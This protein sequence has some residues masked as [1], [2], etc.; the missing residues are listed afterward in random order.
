MIGRDKLTPL[1]SQ[2]WRE[3]W[4]RPDGEHTAQMGH[5]GLFKSTIQVEIGCPLWLM[6][7]P[8][9]RIGIIRKT[10]S[11]AAEQL[12][13]IRRIMEQDEVRDLFRYVHGK[14]P[15]FTTKKD[16]E[17]TW[18]FKTSFTKEG[19]IGAYG[20]N[21]L[22]TGLHLDRAL[23]D[24]ITTKEDRYSK[25]EREKTIRNLQ[26]LLS[27]IIDRGKTVMINGTPW[28]KDDIWS[29]VLE[30]FGVIPNGIK[31]YPRSATGIISDVE[32]AKISQTT[33]PA[34]LA[35]NYDLKHVASE[36]LLFSTKAG[37][38]IWSNDHH[39]VAA[40]L[41]AKF[42]G[43]CTTA[44]TFMQELPE[45]APNGRNWIQVSGWSSP[46]HVEL[47]L[48]DIVDRCIRKRVR[49][50]YNETN[51]DKGM[52]YRAIM[53][54]FAERGYRINISK[55]H[56]IYNYHEGTNK[57][58]KIQ[59]HLLRHWQNLLW[60]IDCDPE[61]SNM[62]MDYQEGAEPNDAPDSAASLLRAFYDDTT[63]GEDPLWD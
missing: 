3:L 51:P 45:K 27:N 22:P 49:H 24:D 31:K 58:Y 19:S 28:H 25:A 48:D 54:K 59:T 38:R 21:Q 43:D 63:N 16:D 10:F 8:E 9:D 11:A 62:V 15:E 4:G 2:M 1:H 40:H 52:T 7:H 23:C 46:K 33:T 26:E 34:L 13:V 5:R 30:K 42:D 36:D 57:Q 17:L 12:A 39:T 32:F 20:I 18:D 6:F 60:D 61:Y 41:D 47:I 37:E 50:F 55:P 56:E 14:A 29:K 44:L 53:A 35:I